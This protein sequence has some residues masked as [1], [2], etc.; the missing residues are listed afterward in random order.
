M[1]DNNGNVT[2]TQSADNLRVE[3]VGVKVTGAVSGGSV[4]GTGATQGTTLTVGNNV[5]ISNNRAVTA[6][7]F[8]DTAADTALTTA[9]DAAVN[10]LNTQAAAATTY[11]SRNK[12]STIAGKKYDLKKTSGRDAALAAYIATYNVSREIKDYG[13]VAAM[14]VSLGNGA[15]S[16]ATL[17]IENT[18]NVDNGLARSSKGFTVKAV[19]INLAGSVRSGLNSDTNKIIK[20]TGAVTGLT[21][22]IGVSLPASVT[23]KSGDMVLS[24][25]TVG[26]REATGGAAA[27]VADAMKANGLSL[28]ASAGKLIISSALNAGGSALSLSASGDIDASASAITAGSVSAR[29]YRGGGHDIDLCGLRQAE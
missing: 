29:V 8:D 15:E 12:T 16:L 21:E 22:A 6:N 4:T 24:G 2:A 1:I 28:T 20:Q 3:A 17:K 25:G 5:T 10:A 11:S 14:G 7:N 27:G 19:G 13:S 23:V 18:A 9:R 26:V